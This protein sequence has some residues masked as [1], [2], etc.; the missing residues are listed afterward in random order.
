MH[1]AIK[2]IER[3]TGIKAHTIR[4]WEKR[5]N[6]VE[7][8]RTDTNIRYYSDND[9]KKLLNTVTLNKYGVKISKI[10]EM[11]E[12]EVK[13][14]VLEITDNA[15]DLK[16]LLEGL[17]LSMI[18]VDEDRFEKILNGCILKFGF[19]ETMVN[20]VYPF[21]KRIGVM[22]LTGTVSPG[23]EHF[24]SN[25]LRQKLIVAIDG[26]FIQPKATSKKFLFFLPEG[27]LHELGLL[28]YQYLVKSKGHKAIYLGQS[29]PIEDVAQISSRNDVK[30]LVTALLSYGSSEDAINYLNNLLP[31]LNGFEKVFVVDQFLFNGTETLP[32][33]V[34]IVK[35][36]KQFKSFLNLLDV[37][38]QAN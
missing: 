21:F 30:Y 38:Q 9:L 20:V 12:E 27:E 33:K 19:E 3:L 18:E 35:D 16:I 2:D 14:K 32:E 11:S 15:R 22:W 5:Y 10:A 25:L 7:P 29:V 8:T 31:K 13:Q 34:E 4:I 17:T 26:Q 23:Q 36:Y 6:I 1:Y 37:Q 24:I 28:F